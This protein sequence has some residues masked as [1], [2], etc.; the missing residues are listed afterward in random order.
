MIG[1]RWAE[2]VGEAGGVEDGVGPFCERLLGGGVEAGLGPGGGGAEAAGEQ[3]CE[4]CNLAFE[5]AFVAAF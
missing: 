4:D 2:D 3:A 1:R 5:T